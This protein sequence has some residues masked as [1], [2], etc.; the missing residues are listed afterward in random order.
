MTETAGGV[1]SIQVDAPPRKIAGEETL[2]VQAD[3]E[4]DQ[5]GVA[6]GEFSFNFV[7]PP[8]IVAPV[9]GSVEG[10]MSVEIKAYGID[11]IPT[12]EEVEVSILFDGTTETVLASTDVN[13]K[14]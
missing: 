12:A 2:T 5:P 13:P 9:D 14:P 7:A 11:P 1:L 8:P 10:G 6:T 3:A 4:G